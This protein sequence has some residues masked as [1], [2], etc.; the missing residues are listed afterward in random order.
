M[1]RWQ[2]LNPSCCNQLAKP[3]PPPHPPNPNQAEEVH[4]A[5]VVVVS[6]LHDRALQIYM[7]KHI[8]ELRAS[9]PN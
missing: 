8:P 5:V 9:I 4:L 6:G 2:V 7:V 1:A 3:P